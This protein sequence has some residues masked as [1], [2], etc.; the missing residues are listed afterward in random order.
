MLFRT[1]SSPFQH[2][3][4]GQALK[5]A[6]LQSTK[7]LNWG[8][9]LTCH[10]RIASELA[11][12][13]AARVLECVLSSLMEGEARCSISIANGIHLIQDIEILKFND[14]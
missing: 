9:L 8:S 4:Y 11:A 3:L 7:L 13:I 10:A 12:S 6:L 1:K 2:F 5:E 14:F